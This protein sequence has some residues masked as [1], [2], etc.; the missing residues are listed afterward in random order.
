[1]AFFP[2]DAL[3]ENLAFPTDKLVL[4]QLRAAVCG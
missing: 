3:P 4:D 2:L 1:V